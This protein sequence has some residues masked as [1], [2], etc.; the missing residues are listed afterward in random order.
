MLNQLFQMAS[1]A[2]FVHSWGFRV[3][4]LINYSQ[5]FTVGCEFMGFFEFWSSS[6]LELEVSS[7]NSCWMFQPP[8]PTEPTSDTHRPLGSS[9]LG[10][11]Y[12]ILNISQKKELLRDL[13]VG[14]KARHHSE[15]HRPGVVYRQAAGTAAAL[16]TL[17]CPSPYRGLGFRF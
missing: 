14:L 13:W 8:D 2:S 7:C 6:L 1:A 15:R 5:L 9:F 3:W 16:G 4:C 17:C 12:R 11:P 10:L